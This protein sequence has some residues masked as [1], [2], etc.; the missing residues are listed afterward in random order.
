MINMIYV[1][2][3][4]FIHISL[5]TLV[6]VTVTGCF[7]TT[8]IL[9]KAREYAFVNM[10]FKFRTSINEFSKSSF[11]YSTM[12]VKLLAPGLSDN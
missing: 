5:R 3:L 2:I 7:L 6:L 10:R 12:N 11:Y 4:Y 8:K 9:N 1:N